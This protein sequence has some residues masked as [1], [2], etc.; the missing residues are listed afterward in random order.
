MADV[1]GI[2]E[3]NLLSEKKLPEFMSGVTDRTC[4]I[5]AGILDNVALGGSNVKPPDVDDLPPGCRPGNKDNAF[6][7][8]FWMWASVARA[9]LSA[10]RKVQR[11]LVRT[12][13]GGSR[14]A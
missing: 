12:V 10:P 11:S 6:A 5:G 8:D 1:G 3:K 14:S 7:D 4:K 13:M 9:R 2:H